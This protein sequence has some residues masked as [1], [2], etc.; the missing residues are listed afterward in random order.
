M[1]KKKLDS[2]YTREIIDNPN[3]LIGKHTYGNPKVFDLGDGGN[4]VIGD[5]C[6]IADDT[7]ILLGGNHRTDWMTTYPFPAFP[8]KWPSAKEI[9]GHPWSKGDVI[10]GND[11]WIG[12]GVT[13]L[14]GV[15]IGDGAVIAARSVVV[16]SIP[17]YT[18]VGG[19]PA[20]KIKDRFSKKTKKKLLQIA[21]WNW[22]EEKIERHTRILCSNDINGLEK[23][24][25]GEA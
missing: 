4:L 21:W 24:S 8:S 17:A 15:H 9:T 1:V 23:I 20:K 6:S 18:I 3:Y 7:T 11:V 10:I 16:K 19:S 12:N 22:P 13:I 2:V 5:Y 25:A 14:S